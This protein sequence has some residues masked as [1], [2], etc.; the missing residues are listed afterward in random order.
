[1]NNRGE[2]NIGKIVV[3]FAAIVFALTAIVTIGVFTFSYKMIEKEMSI[4]ESLYD[5]NVNATVIEYRESSYSDD[6]GYSYDTY[7]PVYEYDGQT[8]VAD[9]S[10]ST[11]EK[12]YNVG[13]TVSVKISSKDPNKMYDPNFNSETEYQS[14]KGDIGKMFL[15]TFLFG[16]IAFGAMIL[17]IIIAVRRRKIEM[18]NQPPEV[19]RYDSYIQNRDDNPYI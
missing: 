3:I 12:K 18:A 5:V 4:D 11:S 7:C 14:F 1:M 9:G 2:V 16:G 8:Y 13:D 17:Y 15:R 10:L 6:E 19:H